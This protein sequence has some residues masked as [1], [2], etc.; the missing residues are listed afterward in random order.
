MSDE[1]AALREAH[2]V[3]P[4]ASPEERLAIGKALLIALG[5]SGPLSAKQMER[6]VAIATSYGASPDAIDA[7]KRFDYA[8]ARI[9]DATKPGAK[10]A[11]H[12]MYEAIRISRAEGTYGERERAKV[13]EAG[14][15][16]RVPAGIVAALEGIVD[17]EEALRKARAAIQA[18]ASARGAGAPSSIAAGLAQLAEQE[19]ALQ[20]TR[21]E[22]MDEDRGLPLPG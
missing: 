4:E 17:G 3:S 1:K 19:S 22:M 20:R 12:L 10:L 15:A 5:A 14:R 9:D 2:G 16:L 13:A 11:R 6:F 21:I 8:R 18:A 7:V